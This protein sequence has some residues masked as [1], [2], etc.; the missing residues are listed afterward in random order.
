MK[1]IWHWLRSFPDRY[2]WF[3]RN[4]PYAV[5][6]G[7]ILAVLIVA[8]IP[9]SACLAGC[10]AREKWCSGD[11]SQHC[12]QNIKVRKVVGC[13]WNYD[14]AACL[15]TVKPMLAKCPNA[16]DCKTAPWPWPVNEC[17]ELSWGSCALSPAYKD[18]TCCGAGGGGGGGGC[19]PDYA[20]PV[21]HADQAVFT[22][23]HPIVF[24]QDPDQLGVAVTVTAEGGKDRN[25]CGG[26]QAKITAFRVTGIDLAESSREWILDDLAAWYPGAHILGDY[27][28][29]P[30]A[31]SLSGKNTSKA[32]LWFHFD[33][34]DPGY[35]E[36]T[37][38]ARQ[39]KG[40]K[41][42]T[43]VIKVPVTL[44]ETTIVH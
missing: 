31:V 35:Y 12:Y 30:D 14:V 40:N 29:L 34:L 41:T 28:M 44:L 27:P 7:I 4:A 43:A 10:G 9:Q 6:L 19:T 38:M 2:P 24:G 23:P 22:P 21:I 33:P 25:N 32:T 8:A 16:N 26:S 1:Q 37:V 15:E 17:K 3:W 5:M 20:P 18:T 11:C 36:A 42:S 39:D 13:T